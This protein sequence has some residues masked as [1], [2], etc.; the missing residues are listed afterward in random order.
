MEGR[1]GERDLT[2]MQE[3]IGYAQVVKMATEI[4]EGLD[5]LH[6]CSPRIIHRDVKSSNILV[7]CIDLNSLRD[8]LK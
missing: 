8:N 6:S 1:R 3:L 2:C 7:V 5:Y 4:A